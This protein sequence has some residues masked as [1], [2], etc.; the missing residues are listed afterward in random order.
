MAKGK[1]PKEVWAE[2]EEGI[3]YNNAINLYDTVRK[4]ENFYIGNQWE[5]AN[6]PD[7][8]KPVLNFLQR[9]VSY[10]VSMIVSD[11]IS[12]SLAPF[13]PDPE[14]EAFCTA[15]QDELERI[16]ERDKT[17]Q[18]NRQ[19]LRNASVDGD[20]CLYVWFDPDAETGQQAQGTIRTE[21]VD[22]INVLFR[23][24]YT[25]DVQGQR[26]I[27]IVQRK[28]LEDVKDEA[29]ANGEDPDE[30]LPDSDEKQ[31]EKNSNNMLCTVLIRLWKEKGE[32][33]CQKTTQ[34]AV[35][36]KAWNTGYQLY[37]VAYMNWLSVRSSYHGR[38]SITGLIP[39]QIAVNKLFAM[40][41][42]SV[43]MNAF[44]KVIF[45]RTKL[46]KWDNAVGAAIG[47]T[48]DPSQAVMTSFRAQDMSGQVMEC[49]DRIVS[50]TRDFMGATDTALGNVSP[51]NTSAIIAVQQASAVPLELIKL[52]FYQ[53]VEDYV[54]IMVDLI[55]QHYGTR[56]VEDASGGAE[57]TVENVNFD[58]IG[59]MALSLKVEIGPSAYWSENSQI[60]TLDNL[61]ASQI[62]TDKALYLESIPDKYVP[63]KEKL[64]ESVR[65]QQAMEMMQAMQA[66]QTTQT[67]ALDMQ[68]PN[69]MV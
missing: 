23:N 29:K 59:D 24:P 58:R 35:V 27:I 43:E 38:A 62:I 10:F 30:I 45:D 2:Y 31:G 16:M 8:P 46:P 49:V 54:R 14:A 18:K 68:V 37:P 1:D 28:M 63:N 61:W 3:D 32:V 64:L 67:P 15:V 40:A 13:L 22:N 26:S 36:R 60:Q 55:R 34:N 41:V 11:D 21:I 44:P 42:R 50:M 39:N 7:L 12:V 33:W 48:G 51:D 53:F 20:A 47:V 66:T 57:Q 4:N 25:P 69:L 65:N 17:K 52:N 56:T 6:A 19:L 5:G 9:V